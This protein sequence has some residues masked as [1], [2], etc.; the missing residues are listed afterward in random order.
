[1][2]DQD[3]LRGSGFAEITVEANDL[4]VRFDGSEVVCGAVMIRL[5]K[6]TTPKRIAHIARHLARG[7]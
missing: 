2:A 5:P 6:S 4:P 7:A 3:K 1:M